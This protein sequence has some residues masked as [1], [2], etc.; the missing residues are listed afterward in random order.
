[1]KAFVTGATGNIGKQLVERLLQEDWSV[2]ALVLPEEDAYLLTK[3]GIVVYQG[4]VCNLTSVDQAIGSSMPDLI[5]HLA[6]YV[7]LGIVDDSQTKNKMY[8]TNV[9]GTCNVLKS[10]LKHGVNK[11]V[12]ISSVAV[13]SA[14]EPSNLVSENT[15]L[16]GEFLDGIEEYEKTKY[17]AYQEA[18]KMQEQG[19]ALLTYLPGVVFGPGFPEIRALLESVY[20]EKKRYLLEEFNENKI[21]LVFCRDLIQAI[22]A[23]IERNAFGEK[24]I[25]VE[26]S[27]TPEEIFKL[28]S[29]VT[30]IETRLKFVS[31]RKALL[32]IWL[33]YLVNRLTLRSS[34][35]TRERA[36][37]LLKYVQQLRY[38]HKFDTSKVRK[39][40]NWEPTPL[41]DAL[42]ETVEWFLR[43]DTKS[44]CDKDV[45]CQKSS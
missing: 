32:G 25:L 19:M 34:R 27:P 38:R 42:Q 28:L 3:E 13:F 45:I 24:Y 29:E 12:Y 6:A 37:N 11:V 16:G 33:R 7:L 20:K 43:N 23:G 35:I 4:D 30:G 15:A 14:S 44:I 17:L 31:Y 10:A 36:G 41:K 1:M 8:N 21:P 5:F 18:M 40:L 26:N 2:D 39:E 9:N 22:F